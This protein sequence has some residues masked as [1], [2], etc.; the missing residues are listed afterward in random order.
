MNGNLFKKT[1]SKQ[2]HFLI[3][4]GFA[5]RMVDNRNFWF[6]KCEQEIGCRISFFITEYGD[7]F[8]VMGLNVEKRFNRVE[9]HIQPVLN[10]VE[11]NTLYTIYKRPDI[12]HIP[13]ELKY[14]ATESNI[15]FM[16]EEEQELLLFLEFVQSFYYHTVIPFF[17]EY[18][19]IEVVNKQLQ[20]LLEE[21]KIQSLLTDSGGNSA[22]LRYYVIGLICK[23]QF[24]I[25]FFENTYFPYISKEKSNLSIKEYNQLLALKEQIG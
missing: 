13:V 15:H 5:L 2:C 20:N 18:N 3:E 12:K 11:L 24:V 14:D 16:I 7:T 17:E 6:E 9:Q 10:D 25:D 23:N 22:I 19:N 21:K 8:H 4:D 1:V